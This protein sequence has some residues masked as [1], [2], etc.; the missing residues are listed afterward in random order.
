MMARVSR[1][2]TGPA[3]VA[4]EH[5][6]RL[7]QAEVH[8]PATVEQARL[9]LADI[10][11]GRAHA[12]VAD[13]AVEAG[14][15]P[16][17]DSSGLRDAVERWRLV[18]AGVAVGD[19]AC[20]VALGRGLA[21]ERSSGRLTDESLDATLTAF[22]LAARSGAALERIVA[23]IELLM[24]LPEII[25]QRATVVRRARGLAALFRTYRAL[26]WSASGTG[27][28][29]RHNSLST[30]MAALATIEASATRRGLFLGGLDCEALFGTMADLLAAGQ[31]PAANDEGDE[32]G[33][34]AGGCVTDLQPSSRRIEFS[35]VRHDAEPPAGG[36]AQPLSVVPFPR[37]DPG[38]LSDNRK[39]VADRYAAL[40]TPLPLT[41]VPSRHAVG[42]ALHALADEMPNFQPVIE[43]I[44]D[45][46]AL[47]RYTASKAAL[48]LPPLL[49]VGPPG[50]GKTR[51]AARLATSLGLRSA[52]LALA[53]GSDNRELSG[54]ARGWSSTHA[55]WPVE[56]LVQLRSANP[57]L[58]VDE[59][60]KAGGS[61]NNG[62]A[63]MSMLTFLERRTSQVYH[64]E[65]VGGPID[66]SAINWM[67]TANT[68][69]GLPG[70]LLSRLIVAVVQAPAVDQVGGM[71]ATM[72]KEIASER[73]MGD[74]RMLPALP[75]SAIDQLRDGYAVH[76]D[77]RRLRTELTRI[78]GVAAQAEEIW[79]ACPAS[80]L[81]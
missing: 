12:G 2:L 64:D 10:A 22:T 7:W 81:H 80:R 44:G 36:L 77:P 28:G 71:L 13:L 5:P 29:D 54:T 49:L 79:T 15:P 3:A 30:I 21:A 63:A 42:E 52:C 18:A 50:I 66:L 41:P 60:D 37:F 45:E 16:P 74:P 46:L 38:R 51:F 34:S 53:G 59:I 32:D 67:L 39:T 58:I 78:L 43:R 75:R 57:L 69:D 65:C 9:L 24:V 27:R 61:E 14:R 33:L 19:A 48:R 20:L 11:T 62:R 40:M 4:L 70:P 23:C 1:R 76:R 47:S 56:Q 6:L 25:G 35:A 17:H 72:Q 26:R 55:S 8:P 73:G 31:L 68:T